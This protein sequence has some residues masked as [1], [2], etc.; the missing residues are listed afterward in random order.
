MTNLVLGRRLIHSKISFLYPGRRHPCYNVRLMSVTVEDVIY[1][2]MPDSMVAHGVGTALHLTTR[3]TDR[4]DLH[5]RDFLERFL[6]ILLGELAETMV[7]SWLLAM[8]KTAQSAVDK[9]T[10]T[11]D[12]GHDLWLTSR[13][14][15]PVTCSVKSSLSALKGLEDIL[16][17]FTLATRPDEVR[18]VNVQVYFWLDVFGRLSPDRSRVT[19]PSLRYAAIVGWAARRD[20]E[21]AEFVPY[22]TERRPAPTLRLCDI[23]PPAELLTYLT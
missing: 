11:P 20:L 8:G 18:D 22:T 9:S 13:D 5:A 2:D 1:L 6:D 23:R 4:A 21:P 7:L 19:L 10:A 16:T 12:L 3:L 17:D 15:R 14:G